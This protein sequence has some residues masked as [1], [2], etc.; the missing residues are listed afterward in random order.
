[1][2]IYL[3]GGI[4]GNINKLWK[5]IMKIYLV[6]FSSRKGIFNNQDIMK[7]YLAEKN[8]YAKE[9][10]YLINFNIK[11]LNIL[12]SYYYVKNQD[13]MFPLFSKFKNFMLDSGAFTFM[14]NKNIKKDWDTYIEQYADFINKQNIKLF[15]E[16]DIDCFVG[17]KEVE[18]L[19]IKLER[20][21]NKQC[22]PVWHK[23]RGKDYYIKMCEEYK[24]IAIGGIVSKEITQEFYPY[25]TWFLQTAKKYNTKVHALGFTN[26]EGL[27]KY[28]FFSV[29]STAWIYGNRAGF[30]YLFN[31]KTM[32]K[33]QIKN[34]K[35]KAKE[36]ALHNF[37]EWT[38]FCE[39]AEVNL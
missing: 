35:L 1:M 18:R 28:P 26:M 12:E 19:R 23:S 21:T 24:Y 3:A 38:K 36:A 2:K 14:E 7:I 17:I 4:T 37:N 30:V 39:Y 27:K 33:K 34:M 11:D 31:G 16:L 13:W 29:D 9:E 5:D 10:K 8:C 22:I 32:E 15:F 25:F 6:S 20:L